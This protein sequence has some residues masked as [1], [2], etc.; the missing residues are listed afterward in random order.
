MT[1]ILLTNDDM[2]V[3]SISF[4]T[5][6]CQKQLLS[7]VADLLNVHGKTPNRHH[8]QPSVDDTTPIIQA[9]TEDNSMTD[10]SK[11]SNATK[12]FSA[13]SKE[14]SGTPNS[15]LSESSVVTS[16]FP[17]VIPSI[18]PPAASLQKSVISK[19]A[20]DGKDEED[21]EE[22]S[23]DRC[24][25]FTAEERSIGRVENNTGT[26]TALS[27]PHLRPE[28]VLKAKG[29]SGLTPFNPSVRTELRHRNPS[30]NP[31]DCTPSVVNRN[32]M[33]PSTS[34]LEGKYAGELSFSQV[35]VVVFF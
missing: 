15:M 8:L 19:S 4:Q 18:D 30:I 14:S 32:S 23:I 11:E 24:V 12:Y 21:E 25:T 2:E 33:F 35:V 5:D 7:F 20:L 17:P 3:D 31:R 29:G 6:Q 13:R 27:G 34:T 16:G 26:D 10:R 9:L 28:S 22:S 1:T